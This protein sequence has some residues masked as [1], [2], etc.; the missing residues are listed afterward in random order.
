MVGV[1]D[2][3]A[4]LRDSGFEI[5]DTVRADESLFDLGLIDSLGIMTLV[6]ELE[7]RFR[8]R[9]PEVDLLPDN[10]DTLNAIASYVNKGLADVAA[11]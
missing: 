1:K 5:D 4:C 11:S 7:S 6:S 2:I 10:F 8:I 3:Q 9:V